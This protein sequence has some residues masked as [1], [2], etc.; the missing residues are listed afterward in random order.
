MTVS[1]GTLDTNEPYRQLLFSVNYYIRNIS[2]SMVG[3]ALSTSSGEELV[4][5]RLDLTVDGVHVDDVFTWNASEPMMT[6]TEFGHVLAADLGLPAHASATIAASIT[7]QLSARAAHAKDLA[8]TTR[9]ADALAATD[10]DDDAEPDD[11]DPPDVRTVIKLNLRI[12]RV[13]VRDQFEWDLS[14]ARNCPESFAETL[15]ADIGL[16]RELIPAVAHSI[17][18]QLP[19][20]RASCHPLDERTVLRKP[21]LAV[22]WEPVVDCIDVREQDELERREKHAASLARKHRRLPSS[23]KIMRAN[24][25]RSL[26]MLGD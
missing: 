3:A 5:I 16:G 17:R 23:D 4:P 26:G 21:S 19:R 20:R 8:A 11:D 22:V 25:R 6:P 15:C 14:E 18:E 12:G 1:A 7:S 24:K 13:A 2:I 10:P 9:E